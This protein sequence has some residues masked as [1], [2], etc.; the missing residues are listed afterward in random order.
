M[1]FTGVR[2]LKEL[3]AKI[4]TEDWQESGGPLEL[5]CREVGLA[6]KKAFLR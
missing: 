3:Y 6:L 2:T 4:S 5:S 1:D